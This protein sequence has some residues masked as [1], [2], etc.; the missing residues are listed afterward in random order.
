[1]QI[2]YLRSAQEYA[3]L[4]TSTQLNAEHQNFKRRNK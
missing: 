3:K 1:M 4:L 2:L